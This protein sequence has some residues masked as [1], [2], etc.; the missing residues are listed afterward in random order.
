MN[1]PECGMEYPL[2]GYQAW[3]EG[4]PVCGCGAVLKPGVVFFGEALNEAVLKGAQALAQKSGFVLVA[5]TSGVVY[6]AAG[7][8]YAAARKGSV[9][10]EINNEPTPL[11][12]SITDYFLKG[13]VE[14]VL[15]LLAT[16]VREYLGPGG[17]S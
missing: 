4:L 17:A 16:K 5:G 2:T 12:S 7:I 15:P 8:P 13:R 3:H 6:P 9:I 10:I 11:T 14:E 1:C